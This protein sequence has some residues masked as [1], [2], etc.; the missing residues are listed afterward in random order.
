MLRMLLN[1]AIALCLSASLPAQLLSPGEFLPHEHGRQFTPHYLLADYA[2]HV[3][4]NSP[5]VQLLRYGSTHEARPLLLAFIS[6]PENLARLEDIRQNNLRHAGLLD[7][8]PDPAL[9]R[10]VVWLSFGVHGNEAGASEASL[11]ALYE[12]ARADRKDIPEWLENTIVIIDPCINPDGFSRYTEWYRRYAPLKPTPEPATYEHDEPWPGG[13]VNHYLFDLNRDWAWQ[14]QIETQS[15]IKKY[16]EWMPHIHVD[17]HEQFPNDHY[18]FAPAAPPYHQYITDWQAEFQYDIGRNHAGY[19]DREGWLYFTREVFDLLYPSYGDTYPTFNGAIGMTHEQAGHG[20]AGLAYEMENG[21]TLTLMDR[22]LHHTATA[23]S[24]VEVASKNAARIVGNFQEYFERANTNPAGKYKTFIIRGD[25]PKGRL[26]AFRQLLDK[27][28]IRYGMGGNSGNVWAYNYQSGQEEDIF[29]EPADLLVSAY[30]PRSVLAQV[31][32]EPEPELEDTLTYDITAW[33]LPYAYGLE[34]YATTRR[35]NPVFPWEAGPG[36]DSPKA[37]SSPYAY[38]VE[39]TSLADAR[40]LA[41]LLQKGVKARFATSAFAI[42]GRQYEAGAIVI[43]LADN[44]KMGTDSFH[45]LIAGAAREFGQPTHPVNTGFSDSGFDLG[46]A[47]LQ[48]ITH[49]RV[50]VLTGEDTYA[51]S[52]GEVWHFFEQSLGY[53]LFPIAPE[54]I[55]GIEFSDYNVLVMPEGEY[56]IDDDAM[57]SLREWI[58]RGGRLIAIGNALSALE[59]KEGF[60]LSR[61]ATEEAE[62]EADEERQQASLDRRLDPYAGQSRRYISR[63]IPGAIFR[64]QLDHTHPLAFGLESYYSLKTSNH[65][66]ELLKDTWNVGF[67][68][69]TPE[70]VGFAG[71]NALKNARNTA[72]FAVQNKGRGAVIYMADNPLF[73]G[74]WENGKFLF[75]NALFFA[76]QGGER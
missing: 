68:G 73:R 50:A 39:W 66:Y 29:I 74:F 26:D 43:S 51:N 2:G 56:D 59:G 30:Q 22:I 21:D 71:A 8:E 18:Y 52:Y 4:E 11:S 1:L 76:G 45:G 61:Y 58:S 23:L 47:S 25:N 55:S 41:A 14:T 70:V 15:R 16:Q 19:F 75:C 49:P 54:K 31:L 38:I 46:S 13:R 67:I 53:P 62:S 12:L 20:I 42:E 27:N 60:S 28:G 33:A 57:E 9:D 64:L 10:A 36:A 6:S 65:F 63:S 24:T 17:F 40:F 44:R 5:R 35:V 72:V 69:E 32:L 3:A 34:A 48:F 37:G 7:G